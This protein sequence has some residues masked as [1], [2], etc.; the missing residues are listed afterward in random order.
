M[1]GDRVAREPVDGEKRRGRIARPAAEA[2]LHG[3]ALGE[4]DVHS[5]SLAGRGQHH[6]G[7]PH[8][9]IG[10]GRACV[11]ALDLDRD[12]L[13]FPLLDLQPIRQIHQTEERLEAVKA[14]RLARE[15]P[16]EEVEL[17]VGRYATRRVSSCRR[18]SEIG[19]GDW[20]AGQGP[21]AQQGDR[22]EGRAV[23]GDGVRGREIVRYTVEGKSRHDG[24][25]ELSHVPGRE[26][27][28]DP[29]N[30]D[31]LEEKRAEQIHRRCRTP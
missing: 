24:R 1:A 23:I 11:G 2:G 8:G 29:Q 10:L 19:Q 7:G 16:Q 18:S 22:E 12:R 28:R 27:N 5:E 20:G 31:T 17:R 3:N 6:R 9:Q 15:H 26:L 30:Q 14:I 13:A 4:R 21:G 25:L